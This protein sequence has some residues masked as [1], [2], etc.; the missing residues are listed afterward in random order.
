[1]SAETG[2][3]EGI[4]QELHYLVEDEGGKNDTLQ[5]KSVDMPLK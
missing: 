4:L 5:D 1:M 2:P 3:N